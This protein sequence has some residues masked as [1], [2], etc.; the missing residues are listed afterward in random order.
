[1][2]LISEKINEA[3]NNQ[4]GEELESA[5]IYLSMSVWLEDKAFHNLS[6]WF[7]IQAQEEFSHAKKF[8]DYILETGGK[9]VLPALSQ[10]KGDWQSVEEIIK[11]AYEHEQ[12]ITRKIRELTAL[13]EEL[14][15]YE[16]LSEILPWFVREQIEEEANTEEL[17]VRQ[18]AYNND[19]LFDHHTKRAAE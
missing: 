11:T 13:A 9:V 8:I 4:I 12:H 18:A 17:V 15:E 16:P 3:F 10:P 14:K 1:M 7:Y 6:N 2:A 19:Y 5:Y